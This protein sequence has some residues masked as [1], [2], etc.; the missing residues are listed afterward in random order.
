MTVGD[1]LDFMIAG[2]SAIGC[3]DDCDIDALLGE[4]KTAVLD[5][6]FSDIGELIRSLSETTT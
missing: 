4:L 3:Q 5:S 1:I 6:G 2:A